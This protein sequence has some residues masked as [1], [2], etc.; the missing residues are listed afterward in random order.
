MTVKRMLFSLIL[1]TKEAC[2]RILE[3]VLLRITCQRTSVKVLR[4]GSTV[5]IALKSK[6]LPAGQKMIQLEELT[7][8]A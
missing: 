8:V 5:M 2:L 6:M 1:S 3:L 7:E 4:L